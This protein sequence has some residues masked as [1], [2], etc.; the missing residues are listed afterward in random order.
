MVTVPGLSVAAAYMHGKAW[1]NQMLHY[2]EENIDFTENY[3]NEHI[4]GI[5]M[6]RPQASYL[7]FLDCRGLQLSTEA[8]SNLFVNKARLALNE[9]TTFGKEGAGFMRMN[10]GCPRSVLKEALDRLRVAVAA[11]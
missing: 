6:I 10:V 1:L 3:L 7:I 11:L 9:G 8:L 2:I 5:R 4:P